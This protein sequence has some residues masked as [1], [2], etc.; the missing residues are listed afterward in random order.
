MI[1]QSNIR[2]GLIPD[3]TVYDL[4]ISSVFRR[5]PLLFFI[6]IPAVRPH[7]DL[8]SGLFVE[9][10]Q[11][12]WYTGRGHITNNDGLLYFKEFVYNLKIVYVRLEYSNFYAGNDMF[13][14]T[15]IDIQ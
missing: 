11:Q 4:D 15:I 12:Q 1:S 13:G 5:F 8:S 6:R 14:D 7:P 9:T 3:V 2:L 10:P